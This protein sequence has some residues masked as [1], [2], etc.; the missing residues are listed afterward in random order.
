MQLG[1]VIK[2]ETEKFA[3]A[4]TKKITGLHGRWD[5]IAENPTVVLD[6]AHN[7][8]GIKQ[9][10]KQ[11]KNDSDQI[12]NHFVLGMVKDKEVDKVLS[13]LPTEAEYY[14][15]NAHIP[16]A[17]PAQELQTKAATFNLK[18]NFYDDVNMA[19]D[20]AKQNAAITDLI[21]VCGSV[22]L[23]GEVNMPADFANYA[24]PTLLN[25]PRV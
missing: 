20:A 4:N 10:I 15:T 19:I 24:E 21:I 12:K 6:V 16:R 23:V 8:D 5:V 13:L 2:N 14:F 11:L 7:E 22:F 9:I 1:F 18:G 25:P 17:L 3:L